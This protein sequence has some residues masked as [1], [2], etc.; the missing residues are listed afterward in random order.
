MGYESLRDGLVQAGELVSLIAQYAPD[1]GANY[2]VWP[3]LTLYRFGSPIPP[4]WDAVNSLSLC[5]VA[6]GRKKVRIGSRDYLYDPLH[7][8]VL[9]RDLRF[10][11]EITEACA[12]Q[13]F[14]SF[15]MQIDPQLVT[16][17]LATMHRPMT[18]LY[19]KPQKPRPVAYVSPLDTNLMGATHRFLLSIDSE[20]DRAV[21]APMYV[22]EIVYRLLLSE[23]R[24]RLVEQAGVHSSRNPVT[25]AIRYMKDTIQ[26]PI[27]VGDIADAVCMSESA[28]AHLFKQ[29]T[30]M[31][32]YKFLKQLRLEAARDALLNENK[33]VTEAASEVG[34]ASLSHFINEFKRHFG[35]TPGTY[36]ERL[37][38]VTTLSL[39]ETSG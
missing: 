15:V 39:R 3:G 9:T 20:I 26:H 25:G 4:H 8:L 34:Y 38:G 30:G 2:S 23:Q 24:A 1:E 18:A 36:A 13:P 29:S 7:Y 12:A 33:S 6:Q 22:R 31:S 16:E 27:L 21:L 10:Q 17:V 14:L 19:Q 11:A 35:E 5:L 28:F 32:P 37:R